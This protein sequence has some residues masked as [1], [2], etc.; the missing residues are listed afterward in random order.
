MIL[1][2]FHL[3]LAESIGT[4]CPGL[5]ANIIHKTP[6]ASAFSASTCRKRGD[7]VG[8]TPLRM[9][10]SQ[11]NLTCA[12]PLRCCCLGGS[13][14]PLSEVQEPRCLAETVASVA[15]GGALGSELGPAG[16]IAGVEGLRTVS[17]E[18]GRAWV[19]AAAAAI[20]AGTPPI[21]PAAP[22]GRRS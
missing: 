3:I 8:N 2:T 22:K 11:R 9:E 7:S 19:T 6:A 12:H 15:S 16:S 1:S 20:T 21:P 14:A 18:P 5:F 10:G 13:C 4:I 17:P